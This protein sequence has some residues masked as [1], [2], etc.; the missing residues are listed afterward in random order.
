MVRDT[1]NPPAARPAGRVRGGGGA[2][3]DLVHGLV[4]RARE[5]GAGARP[6]GPARFIDSS[7]TASIEA[8]KTAIGRAR[9]AANY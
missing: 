8:A 9:S 3:R 2:A 4:A 5:R 7:D 1:A 6:W